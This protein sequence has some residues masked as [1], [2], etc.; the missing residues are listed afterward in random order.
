MK[1]NRQPHRSVKAESG[2][3]P[4]SSVVTSLTTLTLETVIRGRL[5]SDTDRPRSL[6]TGRILLH[7]S[8]QQALASFAKTLTASGASAGER[9]S[10][11]RLHYH[12]LF[13]SAWKIEVEVKFLLG[14]RPRWEQPDLDNLWKPL[15]NA[16]AI[17]SP[18]LRLG[19]KPG[20]QLYTLFANDRQVT[21]YRV[22]MAPFLS[23]SAAHDLAVVKVTA[24]PAPSLGLLRHA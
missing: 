9:R 8:Y 16:L 14:W 1:K 10:V 20:T 24:H 18:G 5:R 23:A 11:R 2:R 7:P 12:A 22:S 17:P 4:A 15:Q 6:S 13:S 19:A 21:S 3:V